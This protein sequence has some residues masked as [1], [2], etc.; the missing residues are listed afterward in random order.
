VKLYEGIGVEPLQPLRGPLLCPS[1]DPR[2][3]ARCEFRGLSLAEQAVLIHG[4]DPNL[5]LGHCHDCVLLFHPNEKRGAFRHGHSVGCDYGEALFLS[6]I[7]LAIDFAGFEGQFPS[8][9]EVPQ[10]PPCALVERHS[11]S[12]EGNPGEACLG[13][14]FSGPGLGFVQITLHA[15]VNRGW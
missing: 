7:D 5:S 1:P 13:C 15:Q 9:A 6:R 14:E 10:R 11:I 4:R 12:I 8:I 3:T 2:G